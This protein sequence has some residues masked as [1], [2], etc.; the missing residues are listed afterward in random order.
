MDRKAEW[1]TWSTLIFWSVVALTVFGWIAGF[2]EFFS[3]IA[4]ALQGVM[5]TVSQYGMATGLDTLQDYL[6]GF[7]TLLSTAQFLTLAGWVTYLIGLYKFRGAQTSQGATN[8]V[9]RV[10]NACWTGLIAMGVSFL[11]TFTP[12]VVAWFFRLIAWVIATISYFMFRSAFR[13]LETEPAWDEKAQQGAALLRKS[14]NFNI[15]LQFMPLIIFMIAL[16]AGFGT[17][18]SVMHSGSGAAESIGMYAFLGIVLGLA[19]LVLSILQ[20]VYRI[21]GW[22]RVMRGAPVDEADSATAVVAAG[23]C[24]GCG[25]PLA[26][27][28]AFCPRCG[29]RV[30]PAVVVEQIAEVEQPE[31]VAGA[32]VE[33]EE[34]AIEEIVDEQPSTWQKYKWGFIGGGAAILAAIILIFATGGDSDKEMGKKTV[35]TDATTMFRLVDGTLGEDPLMDLDYGREV[36]VLGGDSLWVKVR[37]GSKKGYIAFSDLMDTDDFDA[38]NRAMKADE[39]VR[40]TANTRSHRKALSAELGSRPEVNLESIGYYDTFDD[41]YFRNVT[42]IVRNPA[43]GTREYV[44]YGFDGDDSEP[45]RV[46]SEIIPAGMGEV[47]DAVYK[48]GKYRISYRR[49]KS[50]TQKLEGADVFTGYIDGKYEIVMNL[51]SYGSHF[52]GIYYYTKNERPIDIEGDIDED[53][54]LTLTETVV[55]DVTGQFLGEFNGY[56][57]SG[58]W[59][60]PDGEKTLI[61]KLEKE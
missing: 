1:R 27:G 31:A 60:S 23:F 42:M 37:A 28:A 46:Y 12:W 56:G 57:Y 41:G 38:L 29:A 32:A 61:F 16:V 30:Q 4:N 25:S 35:Y 51:L 21:W 54:Q 14:A 2:F 45:V 58:Y 15:W 8:A 59:M 48:G 3:G 10:N 19:I 44:I 36:A 17:L 40:S 49:D 22:H 6:D 53:G 18:Q 50:A 5:D 43:D 11:A 39:S 33:E 20:L 9:R 34:E 26:P 13:D 7:N 52:K 55:G 47:K 24:A